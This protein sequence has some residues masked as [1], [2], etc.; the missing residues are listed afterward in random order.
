MS[1]RSLNIQTF[2]DAR[3]IADIVLHFKRNSLPHKGSYSGVMNTILA[4]VH[5]SW[6]CEHFLTTEEA[7]DFLM[8]EGFSIAQLNKSKAGQRL[9][10][11]MNADALQVPELSMN[12]P[13]ELRAQEL[14]Q[15]LNPD[16]A[17]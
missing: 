4:H 5:A 11:A 14:E 1:T 3:I 10:K 13:R 6:E 8:L 17:A 7:L 2:I 9:L 12:V 16:A 15:V